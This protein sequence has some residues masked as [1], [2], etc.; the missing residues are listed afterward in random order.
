MKHSLI[1]KE[2]N[3]EVKSTNQR[4]ASTIVAISAFSLLCIAPELVHASVEGS[5]AALNEKIVGT[6]L[7]LAAMCGLGI[8][9]ISFVAGHQNARQ[10]L[11]YAMF[12][13]AVGFGAESIVAFIRNLI[14]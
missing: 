7:P 1:L 3:L 12:G 13:A 10:H 14:H 9:A 11:I 6:L 5:L 2:K 4:V 8:A